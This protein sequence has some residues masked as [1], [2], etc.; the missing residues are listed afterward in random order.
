MAAKLLYLPSPWRPLWP[1]QKTNAKAAKV[2]AVVV[3]ATAMADVVTAVA[4]A[5]KAVQNAPKDAMVMAVPTATTVAVMA[6]ADV[7][8]ADVVAS[9]RATMPNVNAST[10]KASR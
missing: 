1:S 10:P 3:T 8:D 6:V 9:A 4:R 2:V 5:A 7:V